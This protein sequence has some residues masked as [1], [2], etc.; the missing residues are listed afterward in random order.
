MTGDATPVTIRPMELRHLRTFA[1]VA[2]TL[3]ISEAARRLR[4]TQPALSRHIRDLEHTVGLPLFV[5]HR[6]GLRLTASGITLREH[7]GKALAAVDAAL[8]SARGAGSKEDAALRVG[9]YGSVSVWASFLAPALEKLGH[10]FPRTAAR[11]VELSCV[12]LVAGL[13]EGWLDVALLGPGDYERIPGVEREVACT[14][15]ALAMMPANHRL[16]KK[17][18]IS[19]DDLREEE[20]IGATPQVAPGRYRSFLAACRA[21]GFTP[22][23]ANVASSLPETIMAV[24]RR[25]GVA[26]VGPPAMA[27][28]HPGMVFIKLRPPGVLLELYAAFAVNAGP[29]ARVLAGLIVAECQRFN[30]GAG[31]N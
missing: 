30:P 31:K 11:L 27:V 15:P 1:I 23:V 14:V 18:L 3:N 8:R 24:K 6:G 20:I 16:A 2:E 5:R 29:V 19:L 28:P 12:Q 22:K 9:Y 21:A 26:I 25:M 17:R 13:R 7:G 4:V 10:K